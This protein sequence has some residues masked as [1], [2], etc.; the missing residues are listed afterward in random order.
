MSEPSL[1]LSALLIGVPY[2]TPCAAANYVVVGMELGYGRDEHLCPTLPHL[3]LVSVIACSL[4]GQWL[5][6]LRRLQHT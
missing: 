1:P 5:V 2:S 6:R 4:R 3:L